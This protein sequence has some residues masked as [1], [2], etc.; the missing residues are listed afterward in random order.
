M[1][2]A[3]GVR[4]TPKIRIRAAKSLGAQAPTILL[5]VILPS[6]FPYIVSGLQLALGLSFMAVV[7]AELIG[8]RSGLGFLIMD[9]QTMLETDK[10]LVGILC[11]GVLGALVDQ[12]ARRL[13]DRFLGRFTHQ[14]A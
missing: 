10:M 9:S 4:E 1:Q 11:L 8:A 14:A 6:A 3:T 13:I 5:K 7:S 12:G 2:T